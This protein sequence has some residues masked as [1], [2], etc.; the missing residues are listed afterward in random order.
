[1]GRIYAG[2]ALSQAF[3]REELYRRIGFSSLEDFL[4]AGWEAN[5]MRRDAN[6]LLAMI[7]TW[8][9]GDISANELY[10]GDL[11]KALGA[12]SATTLV[13]RAPPT[14]TLRS[15]TMNAK[16]RACGMP[17]SPRSHRSGATAPATR[18][19]TPRTTTSSIVR[20]GNC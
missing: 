19:K 6:N 15:P 9:H 11:A 8:Q 14:S 12:I 4:I 17:N 16:S 13:C 1:M 7:W 3:Y 20:S 2:W 10:N 5:Y 18:P